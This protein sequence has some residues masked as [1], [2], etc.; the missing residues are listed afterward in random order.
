[1]NYKMFLIKYAEI[2]TKGKNRSVFEDIMCRRMRALLKR[3]G[4]FEVR[5]EYGRIYVESFS[6]YDYDDVID[7]L[8][9]VF[10]IVGI[11]PVRVVEH[12]DFDNLAKEAVAYMQEEYGQSRATFKVHARRNDKTYPKSSME[13]NCDIGA[14]ILD[15]F[16]DMRV[17]VHEPDIML[18]IEVRNV[19][20]IYSRIIQGPGGLPVGTN[21]K[22]MVLLSGGI[23]SPVAAYMIAKRG[24][25]LEAVYFH[26]PP[27]TSERAKQKVVDL[28]KLV[29]R[30]AG[31]I[32]LHIVNFT[33]V[34]LCIYDNCP[35]DELTI[36]MKRIMYKMAQEIA[37]KEDCQCMIT[38][39]SIGQV[40][41]QTTQSLYVINQAADRLP[42]FRPCIGLDK[43]EIIDISEKIGT[44]ETSILPYEDCCTTFVAKHPVT[45]PK[46][47]QI[48]AS[49]KKLVGKIEE[50]YQKAVDEVQTVYCR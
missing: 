44:Y 8:G 17:D 49:E 7:A 3:H 29:S 48:L 15:A 11:C 14:A 36:I 30:Y 39:E 20:Y 13:I 26:A 19:A 1:M 18:N 6:D 45:R 37:L 40:S 33:D 43:Q 46:E 47:E 24:V 16:P 42:V 12:T 2:G 34:Q 22:G 38:G 25:A 32:K 9:C 5:R 35:H 4:K 21:G 10:G 41:S 27:Y 28:G 31:P 50:L 23:D